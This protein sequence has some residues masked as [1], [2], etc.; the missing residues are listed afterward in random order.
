MRARWG[1]Q[2]KHILG[3]F[4][5]ITP[6]K[7]HRL[8]VAALAQLPKDVVLLVAGGVR[9]SRDQVV[10]D[11]LQRDIAAAG[12]QDRVRITGFVEEGDVP[13][14][15]AACDL[16]LYPATHA[17]S[18]YSLV[19]GLAYGCAPVVASDVYGHREVAE[20]KA[21]IALFPS[22]DAAA[23]ARC[24]EELLGSPERRVALL[25]EAAAYAADNTWSAVAE[26]TRQV[27]LQAQKDWQQKQRMGA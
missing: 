15:I 7:G 6:A 22:G 20:R 2:D 11:D 4:G 13:A 18:S 19:T 1:W 16:L 9:R 14:H 5:Y 21:G 8:A 17:D 3:I 24:S 27:Y 23:L 25:A 10:L 12:L 26:R